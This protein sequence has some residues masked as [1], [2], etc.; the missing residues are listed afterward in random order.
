[1]ALK[2]HKVVGH[3]GVGVSTTVLPRQQ[4]PAALQRPSTG[5]TT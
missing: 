3:G 2:S 1:M 5:A 4:K